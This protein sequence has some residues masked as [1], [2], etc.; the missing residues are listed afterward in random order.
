MC[1]LCSRSAHSLFPELFCFAFRARS[2]AGSLFFLQ[3]ILPLKKPPECNKSLMKIAATV[4]VVVVVVFVLVCRS[5]G[6]L[7]AKWVYLWRSSFLLL[8][9]KISLPA[10][11]LPGGFCSY[12]VPAQ[13]CLIVPPNGAA[14][15]PPW[16]VRCHWFCG[17]ERGETIANKLSLRAGWFLLPR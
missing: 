1:A 2:L 9:I 8:M 5:S 13:C 14:S 11:D 16:P 17:A 3:A 10:G 12:P 6:R 15:W 7:T 4:N